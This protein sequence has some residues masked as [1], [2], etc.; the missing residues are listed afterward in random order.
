MI[1]TEWEGQKSHPRWD[2]TRAWDG[3]GTRAVLKAKDY[4][5]TL[6]GG[7]LALERWKSGD[8]SKCYTVCAE[9]LSQ[10]RGYNTEIYNLIEK[11]EAL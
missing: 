11:A 6:N 5:R 2:L 10:W 8:F 4:E 7:R 9:S 3:T 1:V